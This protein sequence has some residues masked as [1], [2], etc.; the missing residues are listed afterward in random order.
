VGDYSTSQADADALLALLRA[1]PITVY[2]ATGGGPSTV[3]VGAT[4]PYVAVHFVT[5]HANG[6][7]LD[8]KSTRTRTR[9]YAHCVGAND[10]AA[11]AMADQV[12]TAWLDVVPSIAGRNC[13]PIRHETSRDPYSTEPVAL[14]TVTITAVYRLESVPG[15]GS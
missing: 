9:A 13:F 12:Q 14:T 1:R 11:R 8:T 15:E 3:P 4:P 2:P 10:I 5:E 6:D 7:R